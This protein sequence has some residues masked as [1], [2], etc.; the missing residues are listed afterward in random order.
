LKAIPQE[1]R[2]Q[3]GTRNTHR[4]KAG[5]QEYTTTIYLERLLIR[6]HCNTHHILLFSDDSI[7]KFNSITQTILAHFLLIH[8]LLSLS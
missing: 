7:Q 6:R 1:N 3:A 5:M 8:F 2:I 4:I